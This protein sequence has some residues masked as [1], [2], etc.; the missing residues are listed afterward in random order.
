MPGIFI[1]GF[2]NCTQYFKGGK[3]IILHVLQVLLGQGAD[4]SRSGIELVDLML[5]HDLPEA[6]VMRMIGNAFEH[7]R[8]GTVEQRSVNNITMTGDPADIGGA[9]VDIIFVVLEYIFEGESG[10][11]HI[12]RIGVDH[13]LGHP[14]GSGGVEDEQRI[15]CFDDLEAA[16]SM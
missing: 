8:C 10:V 7:H 15:L 11:D 14:G 2:S 5:F 1:D 4:D 12:T 6:S 16:V 3:I 9:P 13:S